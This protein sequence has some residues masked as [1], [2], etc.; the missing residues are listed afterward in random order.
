MEEEPLVN[1]TI[2]IP[3]DIAQRMSERGVD[4]SR[5][6]SEAFALD[7]FKRARISKAELR[8]LLGFGTRWQLDGF[9]NAH[10]VYE[11]YTLDDFQQEREALKDLGF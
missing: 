6:A 9:L 5:R 7:E 3:D 1:L 10:E 8:R 4:L 11:E 2:E